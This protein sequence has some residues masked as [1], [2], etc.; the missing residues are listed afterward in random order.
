MQYGQGWKILGRL[1]TQAIMN[2]ILVTNAKD[3]SLL[4]RKITYIS[5]SIF[6]PY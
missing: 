6:I 4:E 1:V 2:F 5:I 3:I